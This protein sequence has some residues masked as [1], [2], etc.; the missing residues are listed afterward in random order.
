MLINLLKNSPGIHR[1]RMNQV[2]LRVI[3]SSKWTKLNSPDELVPMARAGNASTMTCEWSLWSWII[4]CCKLCIVSRRIIENQKKRPVPIECIRA[5]RASSFHLLIITFFSG[6]INQPSNEQSW[7]I[8]DSHSSIWRGY[9]ADR[10]S[11]WGWGGTR[12]VL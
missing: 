10:R 1:N 2:Q 5:K 3:P 7:W 11:W 9:R 12:R 4:L 6:R 8:R